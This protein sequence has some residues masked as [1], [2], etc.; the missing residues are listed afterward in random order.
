MCERCNPL[1][2]KQP[3]S[4]QA[5]GTVFVGIVLAVIALAVLGRVALAGVGPFSGSIGGVVADPP[6]LVVTL[7]VT[8]EGTKAGATTCRIFDPTFTGIGPEADYVQSPQI[9]A[10]ATVSFSREVATLGGT[11]RPLGVECTGP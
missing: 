8:N 1:G 6:N 5:H 7:T 3:A 11:V 2:L 10:G 9:G 4:S